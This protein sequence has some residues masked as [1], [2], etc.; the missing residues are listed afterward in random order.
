MDRY[1]DS[2]GQ[3]Y[4]EDN[5]S[6]LGQ[7]Y[8]SKVYKNSSYDRD[9]AVKIFRDSSSIF[10]L[11]EETASIISDLRLYS[12]PTFYSTLKRCSDGKH[13]GYVMQFFSE[14]KDSR[15]IDM[16]SHQLLASIEDIEHDIKEFSSHDIFMEDVKKDNF[17]VTRDGRLHLI[18]YDMFSHY[19][20]F[21]VEQVEDRNRRR[22][23]ALFL[24][25]FH[26]EVFNDRSFT[27]DE[28]RG[29]DQILKFYLA[30]DSLYEGL[31]SMFSRYESPRDYFEKIGKEFVKK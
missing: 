20:G 14:D 17:V 18:D 24:D 28:K 4:G 22:I 30:T 15:V 16:D 19:P 1:V 8:N 5:L 9:V 6:Y 26:G 13:S 3:I 7:G 29:I 25:Y 2:N 10:S 21:S 12:F 11:S 31:E 27:S 23:Q